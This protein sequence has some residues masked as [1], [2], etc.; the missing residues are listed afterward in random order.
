MQISKYGK[1]V[2]LIAL[3]DL[4]TTVILISLGMAE[5]AQPMLKWCF[6]QGG[7]VFFV[8]VKMFV[9]IFIPVFFGELALKK[10]WARPKI[11]NAAYIF[12]IVGYL[13]YYIIGVVIVNLPFIRA[14]TN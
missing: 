13:T 14:L 3:V 6:N 10:S 9:F 1:I 11:V 12:V 4:L 7:T 2:L 8:I 5:E